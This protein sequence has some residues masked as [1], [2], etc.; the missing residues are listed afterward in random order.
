M[1]TTPNI[2]RKKRIFALLLL[3]L[4]WSFYLLTVWTVY[5]AQPSL[6]PEF[7]KELRSFWNILNDSFSSFRWWTLLAVYI[8]A[9]GGLPLL[10]HPYCKGFFIWAILC[11]FVSG[12]PVGF[13]MSGYAIVFVGFLLSG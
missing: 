2:A 6:T 12:V 5:S 13:A 8:P 11:A 7:G 1:V 4:P 9:A 3:L 10:L